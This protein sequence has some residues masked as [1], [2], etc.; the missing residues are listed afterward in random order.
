MALTTICVAMVCVP[1]GPAL[2]DLGDPDPGGGNATS[3]TTVDTTPTTEPTPDSTTTTTTTTPEPDPSTTT[4]TVPD[5]DA[6]ATAT[7]TTTTPTTGPG[8]FHPEYVPPVLRWNG[9]IHDHNPA[10]VDHDDSDGLDNHHRPGNL[11]R[12]GGGDLRR[13]R[14]GRKP[15]RKGSLGRK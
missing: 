5:D 8:Q 6:G 15:R 3:S 14:R 10:V 11:P 13:Q 2:A 9:P 7:S 1:A 4:T 12:R